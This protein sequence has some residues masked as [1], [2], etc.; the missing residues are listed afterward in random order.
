LCPD[1]V[2][3]RRRSLVGRQNSCG[4]VLLLLVFLQQVPRFLVVGHQHTCSR[5]TRSPAQQ[6]PAATAMDIATPVELD[7]AAKAF[8]GTLVTRHALRTHHGYS[9]GPAAARPE[10]ARP[11]L[12]A[13]ARRSRS[14]ERPKCLAQKRFRWW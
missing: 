2:D 7:G 9:S 12:P 10:A 1:G 14:A 11:R 6:L 3:E 13:A 5:A 8:R 4:F